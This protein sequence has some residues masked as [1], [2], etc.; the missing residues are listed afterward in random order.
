[1]EID[2]SRKKD[3]EREAQETP[4]RT[5]EFKDPAVK[6][7][8]TNVKHVS[9]PP[10]SS[11]KQA[12]NTNDVDEATESESD[13]EP[14]VQ[15]PT[16]EIVSICTTDEDERTDPLDLLPA[17]GTPPDTK[18]YLK[19]EREKLLGLSKPKAKA[20]DPPKRKPTPPQRIPK[21]REFPTPNSK[22]LHVL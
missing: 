19:G 18:G 3:N 4:Q 10:V 20:T 21:K 5:V 11:Q 14:V 1:M 22:A 9:N 8:G 17:R 15:A 16:R 12:D 13:G 6:A 2:I 7:D